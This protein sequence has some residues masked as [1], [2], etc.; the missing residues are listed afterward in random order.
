[1]K[2]LQACPGARLGRT[3]RHVGRPAPRGPEAVRAR[4]RA[5]LPR[6]CDLVDRLARR[7]PAR[8]ARDLAPAP[9]CRRRRVR[10]GLPGRALALARQPVRLPHA[11]LVLRDP[12]G[13]ATA[14]AL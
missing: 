2:G 8:G 1:M 14:A 13:A 12:R 4:A 3:L 6:G 10:D 9:G 7:E 5:E 11:V